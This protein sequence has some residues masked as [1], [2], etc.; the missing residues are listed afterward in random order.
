MARE[1]L[2]ARMRTSATHI[3]N[4]LDALPY[5]AWSRE[6]DAGIA[7]LLDE[8]ANALQLVDAEITAILTRNTNLVDELDDY[9][10]QVRSLKARN[11][12]IADR[13]TKENA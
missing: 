5:G 1:E 13:L 4:T 6:E 10:R 2:I 11:R 3:R 12:L 9:A 8:A 7:A